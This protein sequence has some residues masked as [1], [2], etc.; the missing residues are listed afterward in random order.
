M[1]V[2]KARELMEVRQEAYDLTPDIAEYFHTRRGQAL[3]GL[4]TVY[5]S[6][7]P[8]GRIMRAILS[9]DDFKDTT[10]LL[11][12]FF[13]SESDRVIFR[14]TMTA[15]KSAKLLFPA[16]VSPPSPHALML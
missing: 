5:P 14:G 3:D 11:Q 1:S 16:H 7:P 12:A 6:L 13:E 9:V 4:G 15:L 8:A 10:G 2:R